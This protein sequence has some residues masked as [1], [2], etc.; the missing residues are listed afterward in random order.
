MMGGS[1]GLAILASFAAMKSQ[2]LTASG[3]GPDEALNGGYHL[4]FLMG[5][6]AAT[7]AAAVGAIFMRTRTAPAGAAAAM[8]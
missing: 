3:V 8:H 4:A 6:I 1:L 2:A 5:A 7:I